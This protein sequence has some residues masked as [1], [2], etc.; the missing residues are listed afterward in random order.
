VAVDRELEAL[1]R[2]ASRFR[3]DS[4]I[5]GL[6]RAHGDHFLLS[7]GLADALAVALAA[8]EWTDG[9]VDPTVGGSLISLGYDRDFAAIES[10]TGRPCRPVPP[11]PG[12][13]AV[14]LEGRLC[15]RPRGIVLDLGAT[16]KAL[17]A[18]RAASAAFAHVGCSGGVL[19]SLGGDIAL[20]GE[21]PA[22]GWPILVVEDPDSHQGSPTQL[23][24]LHR[25]ALAT[26]SVACRRWQRGEQ[27]LHHIIDPRTGSPSAGRWRTATV[28]APSCVEANAAST[29][30]MV[31][32]AEVD[33]FSRVGLP[34]RLVDHDGSV[35]LLG[36]W[37]EEDDETL[38]VPYVDHL[39]A[40]IKAL[41]GTL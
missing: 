12:W 31:G 8:A 20:A 36:S 16:A 14:R 30:L 11:A 7:V 19:V 39:G 21:C 2:Q 6:N 37:P 23:V 27:A 24:R 4:E 33:W 1:D 28:A 22:G 15:Q 41:R 32:G 3:A 40:R 29:A 18:D 35:C 25:G 38:Q 26:S 5:C 10:G 34:A 13:S 9:L 17:G